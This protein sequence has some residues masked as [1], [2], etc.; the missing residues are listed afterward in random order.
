M[1]DVLQGKLSRTQFTA[2][3]RT[4]LAKFPAQRPVLADRGFAKDSYKYPNFNAQIT[5]HFL[6]SRQQFEKGETEEDR[7]VCTLRY[8]SEV[9]FSLIFNEYALTDS[10]PYSFFAILNDAWDWGHARAN[11]QGPL[12]KPTNWEEY[13]EHLTKKAA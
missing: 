5:P 1:I 7:V 10:I 2:V 4:R 13:V 3:V 6:A 9:I 12:R 8:T 11:L